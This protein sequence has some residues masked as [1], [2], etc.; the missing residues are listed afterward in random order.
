L[1]PRARDLAQIDNRFLG[2][3]GVIFESR[4][5][6][7]AYS[8]PPCWGY[9]EPVRGQSTRTDYV[10]AGGARWYQDLLHTGGW[11]QRYDQ[12]SYDAG[13]RYSLDWLAPITRPR[14][15]PGYWGPTR[16]GDFMSVN[17]PFVSGG[18]RVTGHMWDGAG[19]VESRL[20]YGDDLL[21]EQPFQAVFADA[22]TPD[23]AEYRFVQDATRPADPW[24]TS[25]RT[26]T[27]WT[28]KSKRSAPLELDPLPL[29]QLDYDVDTDLQSNVEAGRPDVIGISA[30][31]E[32]GAV[33]GGAVQ[34]VTLALSYDDGATWRPLG[35]TRASSGGWRATVTYPRAA[36]GG[37]V[38]LKA[39]ARDDAGNRVEQEI[40]RAYGL[41]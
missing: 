17:V 39:T 21:A 26:H 15:G 36:R 40:I 34:G 10:S 37:Y 14:L 27:A 7:H 33:G 8:L 22:P 29:L 30:K 16:D 38:S 4:A 6:C 23:L 12:A 5:D 11:E 41:R 28:F 19:T 35:L 1:S 2:P 3:P 9:Y 13:R 25:I 31:H 20:Y 18:S 32:P 24:R